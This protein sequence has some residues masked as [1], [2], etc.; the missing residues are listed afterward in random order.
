MIKPNANINMVNLSGIE[1]D[2]ASMNVLENDLKFIVAP[3]SIPHEDII[4]RIKDAII[5]LPDDEAEEVL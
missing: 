4:C 5:S 3:S 1:L 2:E